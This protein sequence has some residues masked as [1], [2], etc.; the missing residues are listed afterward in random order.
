MTDRHVQR[1]AHPA[2]GCDSQICLGGLV[3]YLLKMRRA[4][5]YTVQALIV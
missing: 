2:N 3:L 4:Y 1:Y 5:L